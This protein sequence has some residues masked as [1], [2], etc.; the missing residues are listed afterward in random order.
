MDERALVVGGVIGGLAVAI[1]LQRTGREV[2]VLERGQEFRGV[3]AGISLWPNAV[4]ALRRL[5][6]GDAVETAAHPRMTPPSA[7]GGARSSVRR[8]RPGCRGGSALRS[9]SSTARA[10]RR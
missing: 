5:G 8:S 9:S 2:V 1:A 7:A 4:N 3:G 6:I 10:S